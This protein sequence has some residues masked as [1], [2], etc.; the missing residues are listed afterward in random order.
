MSPS[1]RTRHQRVSWNLAALFDRFL[2][3]HPL[4]EMFCAPYDVVLSDRDVVEPD[5]VYVS[6][7]HSA[8]I[9]DDHIKG[10]PDLVIEI[11]SEGSRN[12]D[13]V[14][15]WTLYQRY[16]VAEYW[17]VDPE[18][19]RVIVYRFVAGQYVRAA[20]LVRESGD[21]LTSDLFPGLSLPL[22]QVFEGCRRTA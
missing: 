10:A 7:V 6:S 4:G 21:C 15:K 2:T 3:A 17:I 13:E 1:P 8:I 9:T 19:E 12:M 11:L 16:G 5:L 18:R 20:V 22:V 14:V